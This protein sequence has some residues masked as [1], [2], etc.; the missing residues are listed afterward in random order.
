MEAALAPAGTSVTKTGIRP[1]RFLATGHLRVN[2][3]DTDS[4]IG[5]LFWDDAA[6]ETGPAVQVRDWVFCLQRF[7]AADAQWMLCAYRGDR[8][9]AVLE[10]TATEMAAGLR[11]AFLGVVVSRF[12]PILHPETFDGQSDAAAAALRG[13]IEV[14][15][16][17][18]PGELALLAAFNQSGGTVT[19]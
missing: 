15:T 17:L 12:W 19:A 1:W 11:Q 14:V 7:P 2:D 6:W 10:F 8:F 9:H 18:A 13:D 4:H 3:R 5:E 16:R